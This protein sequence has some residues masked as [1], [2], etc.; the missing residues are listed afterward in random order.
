MSLYLSTAYDQ[1]VKKWNIWSIRRRDQGVGSGVLPNGTISRSQR[2]KQWVPGQ[3][4][5][6]IIAA[7]AGGNH[8]DESK[9]S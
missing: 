8:V 6:Y 9:G 1:A 4:N 7:A 5:R 3:E 2:Q